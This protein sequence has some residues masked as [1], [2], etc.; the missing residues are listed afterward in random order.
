MLPLPMDGG[1]NMV[2]KLDK[3]WHEDG[4]VRTVRGPCH[5]Y[6]DIFWLC[7]QELQTRLSDEIG[8]LRSF[9]SSRGSGDRASH[10][11]ERSS[12]ELEVQG[13]PGCPAASIPPYPGGLLFLMA[14]ARSRW[15]E[16]L[17]GAVGTVQEAEHK[18]PLRCSRR[19]LAPFPAPALLALPSFSTA[20]LAPG[21]ASLSE[22]VALESPLV[23]LPLLWPRC[24]C[25]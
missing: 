2:S 16:V 25:G 21:P 22:A 11:N 5:G 10:N 12:C 7:L 15:E 6:C 20:V 9:I 4:M 23:P 13:S 19:L 3:G 18:P 14:L 17:N 1:Y 8:K 24:C